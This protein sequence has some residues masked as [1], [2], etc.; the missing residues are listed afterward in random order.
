MPGK[1]TATYEGLAVGTFASRSG[2]QWTQTVGETGDLTMT[3][4]F[5]HRVG[6]MKVEDFGGKDFGGV[7][8][9]KGGTGFTGPLLGSGLAVGQANGSFVQPDGNNYPKG[10]MGNFGV[11]NNSWKA[12]GIFG[13]DLRN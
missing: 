10:V 3:W 2:N 11:G 12:N 1:G 4:N 13:G 9:A 8:V 7:M 5:S 6:S